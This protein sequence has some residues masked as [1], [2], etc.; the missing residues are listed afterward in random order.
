MR[1][2]LRFFYGLIGLCCSSLP[3]LAEVDFTDPEAVTTAIFEAARTGDDSELASLCDPL[4]ENDG[5]TRQYICEMT[6]I[7]E[8]WSEYV[9][10]FE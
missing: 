9:T 6:A 10:Y 5:D 7:S 4:G 1:V 3:A 8:G 2:S